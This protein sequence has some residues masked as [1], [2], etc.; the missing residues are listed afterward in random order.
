M[1]RK[2]GDEIATTVARAKAHLE[3]KRKREKRRAR[4]VRVRKAQALAIGKQQKKVARC[5]GDDVFLVSYPGIEA[6]PALVKYWASLTVRE[7]NLAMWSYAVRTTANFQCA[8]CGLGSQ[9]TQILHAHHILLKSQFSKFRYKLE[10]GLCLC[11]ECHDLAHRLLEINL[12]LYSE[13][14]PRLKARPGTFQLIPHKEQPASCLLAAGCCFRVVI[15][16]AS[17][18]AARQKKED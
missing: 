3:K 14:V 18:R 5:R 2:N 7:Q 11:V 16:K 6:P 13:V 1:K 4:R 8:S 12:N 9:K 15:S 10:N 17:E